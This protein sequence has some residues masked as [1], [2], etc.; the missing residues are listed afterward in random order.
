MIIQRNWV[1]PLAAGAFLL[2]AVTGVLIFFHVDSGANKFVHEWLSWVLLVGVALHVVANLAGLKIH[3]ASVR[4]RLLIGVFAAALLAS[5]MQ[6]GAF[7]DEPPFVQPIR[8]LSQAPLSTLALVAKISPEQLRE[9]LSKAGF[10]PV[11]DQQSVSDLV[12]S[13]LKQQMHVLSAGK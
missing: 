1:T 6:F 9:N 5:F 7:S 10:Q 11:S 13:D 12:G 4:G 3:L 2:S 8:S